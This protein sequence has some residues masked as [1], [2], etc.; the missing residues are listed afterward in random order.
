MRSHR[1]SLILTAVPLLLVVAA[2]SDDDDKSNDDGAIPQSRL[3]PGRP[4]SKAVGGTS[5][6]ASPGQFGLLS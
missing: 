3:L 6:V 1:A 2:C 5:G 4:P